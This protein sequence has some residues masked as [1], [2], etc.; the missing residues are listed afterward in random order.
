MLQGHNQSFK[1][2]RFVHGFEHTPLHGDLYR[3]WQKASIR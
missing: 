3:V 2:P 1:S